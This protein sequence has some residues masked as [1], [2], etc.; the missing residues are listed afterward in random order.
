MNS[1]NITLILI[2]L[3]MTGMLLTIS[4]E[5]R[6]GLWAGVQAGPNF[7][8]DTT[9]KLDAKYGYGLKEFRTNTSLLGGIII[10]YDFVKEGYLGYKWPNWMKYFSMA[11]DLTYNDFS[12]PPQTARLQSPKVFSRGSPPTTYININNSAHGYMLQLSLFFI[13]RYGFFPSPELPFGRLIPYVGGGPGL[14]FSIVETSRSENYAKSSDSIEPGLFAE[15]GVR[16]MLHPK[17]SLDAALRYRY[18]FPSY[19]RAYY[20]DIG[21]FRGVGRIV[22]DQFNALFRVCYHF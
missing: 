2:L 3:L 6:A 22:V 10:G 8:T 11:I 14:F 4:N 17:V 16:Y 18:T 20:T 7:V 13:A 12:Q 5:S 15:A 9:V 1:K 21:F 19:D